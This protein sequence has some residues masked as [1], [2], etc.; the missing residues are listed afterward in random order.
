MFVDRQAGVYNDLCHFFSFLLYLLLDDP[1]S[2]TKEVAPPDWV[3]MGTA[4]AYKVEPGPV[5][6][7]DGVTLC[8]EQGGFITSIRS[9]AEYEFVQGETDRHSRQ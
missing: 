1:S 9:Q 7:S 3:P 4:A 6:H 5:S 2:I 8:Q